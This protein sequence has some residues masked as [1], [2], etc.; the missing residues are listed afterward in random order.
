MQCN[1]HLSPVGAISFCKHYVRCRLLK[2]VQREFRRGGFLAPGNC[3]CISLTTKGWCLNN[4]KLRLYVVTI[5][6]KNSVITSQ[7]AC[8]R[9]D[10]SPSPAHLNPP[11]LR[12]ETSSSYH[13]VWNLFSFIS[14]LCSSRGKSGLQS[15]GSCCWK[16]VMLGW[17]KLE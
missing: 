12:S 14:F 1:M 15:G 5:I 13:H 7:A 8:S 10:C 16:V 2:G 4:C 17:F 9:T 6:C 3:Y 11:P